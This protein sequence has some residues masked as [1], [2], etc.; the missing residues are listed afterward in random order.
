MSD[1]PCVTVH[2]GLGSES[3]RISSI[4][5]TI[6]GL[7]QH[8]EENTDWLWGIGKSFELRCGASNV[9]IKWE[10]V[11]PTDV[12]TEFR[13][14]YLPYRVTALGFPCWGCWTFV[15]WD[16]KWYTSHRKIAYW[17]KV[18]FNINTTRHQ[19][20]QCWQD[21][22]EPRVYYCPACGKHRIV[23]SMEV[24]ETDP[25]TL[26]KRYTFPDRFHGD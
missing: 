23:S 24:V 11:I 15:L 22:Y 10:H 4:S 17:P 7:V 12:A 16:A 19:C 8:L 25:V 20:R 21:F 5:L 6:R 18:L 13:L 14:I 3:V 9:V 2:R 26:C 1:H